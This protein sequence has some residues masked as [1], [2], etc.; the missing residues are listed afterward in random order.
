MEG[1][2]E[3]KAG[4]RKRSKGGS[5]TYRE[6]SNLAGGQAAMLGSEA[7]SLSAEIRR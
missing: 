3:Q 2:G 7:L 6:E 5:R 4:V 1:R